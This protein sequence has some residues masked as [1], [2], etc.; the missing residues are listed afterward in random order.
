MSLRHAVLVSVTLCALSVETEA[1]SP[2]ATAGRRVAEVGF[3]VDVPRAAKPAQKSSLYNSARYGFQVK[4]P[5]RWAT[6]EESSNFI[7]FKSPGHAVVLL[8][9]LPDMDAPDNLS[10]GDIE[11]FIE[12][13]ISGSEGFILLDR[14]F[15]QLPNRRSAVYVNALVVQGGVTYKVFEVLTTRDGSL[16]M[17]W[18]MAEREEYDTFRDPA[19]SLLNSF[20]FL[21]EKQPT[22]PPPVADYTVS[23]TGGPAP[24]TVRFTNTSTGTGNTYLW[25]FGDGT[26]STSANPSHTFAS[27]GTY[28]IRLT[29]TNAGGSNSAAYSI[30]VTTPV[31]PPS[32]SFTMSVSRG[33]APL[34]VRFTNTSTGTGNTYSWNFGDGGTNRGSNPSYTYTQSGTYTIRLTAS[35]TGGTN[36][37]TRTITVSPAV[38]LS[39]ASVTMDNTEVG[40]SSTKTITLT[41]NGSSGVA[42]SSA[43][44]TGSD[45]SHFSVSPARATVAAGRSQ[46][47]TVTFSP[48][49]V[50]TKR[51]SLSIAHDKTGS[52]AVVALSGT[53]TSA[54][55]VASG[56]ETKTSSGTLGTTDPTFAGTNRYYDIYHVVLKKG[57]KLSVSVTSSA[58]ISIEGVTDDQNQYISSGRSKSVRSLTIARDGNYY[59]VISADRDGV[60]GSYSLSV[61]ASPGPLK[62]FRP[63]SKPVAAPVVTESGR[64]TAVGN[65]RVDP[66]FPNPFNSETLIQ[67]QLNSSLRVQLEVYDL[68]GQRVR[69]LVEEEQGKGTHHVVWDGRDANG[70]PVGSGFYLYHIQAGTVSEVG[71]MLLVR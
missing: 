21:D 36:S 27:A 58:A 12:G 30:T 32:A 29:A 56:D 49:S 62:T 34:T 20:E 64:G 19:V 24:L 8:Y 63:L 70:N 14:G 33:T 59:I 40:K 66:S 69:T 55:T 41:N 25:N 9:V 61:T 23:V 6:T 47:F 2:L 51:A 71:R 31:T 45:A 18:Y 43:S 54:T 53:A 22:T 17:L 4:V 10:E 60:T 1:K 15:T 48:K 68:L 26:T 67:Y 57:Q 39:T 11:E 35:N 16:F 50:G 46:L 52:P 44:L 65:L 3:S 7:V 5:D 28:T 38:V 42:V 37:T 13:Q